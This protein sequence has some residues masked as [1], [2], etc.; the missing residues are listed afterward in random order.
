MAVTG[1]SIGGTPATCAQ[2]TPYCTHSTYGRQ[3]KYR[4]PE[5]CGCGHCPPP[6]PPA[7]PLVPSCV[8]TME[9]VLV[10]DISGSMR[11]WMDA[12]R[13]FAYEMALS[14]ELGSGDSGTRVGV[15]SFADSATTLTNLTGEARRVTEAINSMDGELG[16]TNS[17]R[18]NTRAP[19]LY[20]H[21]LPPPL[22][23]SPTH[24][25]LLSPLASPLASPLRT[26]SGGL[27][28]ASE[29]LIHA[30]SGVA[31]VVMVLTDGVQS[32]A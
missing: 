7:P 29:L 21:T 16:K 24:T 9:L 32:D 4:C 14:F 18:H 6:A 31:R 20:L 28:S 2:L 30:R 3:I 1:F 10:I 23:L 25:C 22:P 26:V 17:A 12:V 19:A 27:T 15:V 11:A 8:A 13:Q 5:S